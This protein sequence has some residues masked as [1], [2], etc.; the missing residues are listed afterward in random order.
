MS[1]WTQLPEPIVFFATHEVELAVFMYLA[2]EKRATYG[3]IAQQLKIHVDWP[4][5]NALTELDGRGLVRY[6]EGHALHA[7]QFRTYYL[8][9]DGYSM[10]RKLRQINTMMRELSIL[11]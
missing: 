4:I 5:V 1:R 8:T 7:P 11:H 2:D 6:I 3:E 10:S 9:A